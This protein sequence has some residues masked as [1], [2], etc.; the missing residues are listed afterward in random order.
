MSDIEKMQNKDGEGVKKDADDLEAK[1]RE[2]IRTQRNDKRKE[3]RKILQ[4]SEV[5]LDQLT[6]ALEKVEMELELQGVERDSIANI[7]TY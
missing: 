6:Q 1:L 5:S 7:N 4:A 2:S 3:C